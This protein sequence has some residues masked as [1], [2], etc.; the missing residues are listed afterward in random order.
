MNGICFGC[1]GSGRQSPQIEPDAQQN[2]RANLQESNDGAGAEHRV[3]V[4]IAFEREFGPNAYLLLTRLRAMDYA[5]YK[6]AIRS[7]ENGRGAE[8]AHALIAWASG[9]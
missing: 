1:W 3:Q 6:K 7:I 8:V 2:T 4:S 9:G 5:R